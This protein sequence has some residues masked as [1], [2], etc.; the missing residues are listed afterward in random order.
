MVEPEAVACSNVLELNLCGGGGT[1]DTPLA[2]APDCAIRR[3]T[4]GGGKPRAGSSPARR[5]ISGN[6][7]FLPLPRTLD[8][9]ENLATGVALGNPMAATSS[10]SGDTRS[11]SR[12]RRVSHHRHIQRQ[13]KTKAPRTTRAWMVRGSLGRLH[14]GRS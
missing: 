2:S 4:S 3:R 12:G 6:S 14:M 8:I 5:T 10:D 11:H 1:A 9:D 13:I 7:S